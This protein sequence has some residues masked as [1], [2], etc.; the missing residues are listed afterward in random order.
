MGVVGDDP[1]RVAAEA[2]EHGVAEA[3]HRPVAD[4]QVEADRGDRIDQNAVRKAEQGRASARIGSGRNGQEECEA[5][6]DRHRAQG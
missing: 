5:E 6:Q 2:E 4:D 1:D 3:D